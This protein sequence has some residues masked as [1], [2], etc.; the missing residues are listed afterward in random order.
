MSPRRSSSARLAA[1]A[2]AGLAAVSALAT[3]SPAHAVSGVTTARIAGNDRY[4]T[5]AAIALK[6]YTTADTVIVASG[7]SF[8]DALAG[9]AL[10]SRQTAP[11]LL[12][13]PDV[14]STP[15]SDAIAAL[16]ATKAVILGGTSAVSQAVEDALAKK[17]SVSRISGADRYDTAAKIA[18]AIGSTNIGTT[19]TRRSALIATGTGFAD[20]LAG[21]PLSAAGSSGVLPV[22]LVND[23]VPAATK[24]ALQD[25]G[26]TQTIILGGT[27]AVSTA[28][29]NDLKTI[30]GNAPTRL[31]GADRYATASAIAVAE[32]TTFGFTA[33]N[34]YL[35]NGINFADAL[36][37]G[38]L[39]GKTKSPILLSDAASLASATKTFLGDHSAAIVTVTALG[40]T[41]ALSDATL[42]A[43]KTAASGSATDRKNETIVVTPQDK[44]ILVN[45]S[46]AT[47]SYTATGVTSDVDIVLVNCTNVSTSTSGNTVFANT[48]ADGTADGTASAG[49]GANKAST[50]ASISTVNGAPTLPSANDDYADKASPAA[51]K[52]TF[53]VKAG[54]AV[55]CVVPVVFVDSDS[56]NSLASSATGLPSE[57]FGTGGIVEFQPAV[58]KTGQFDAV[59][60]QSM[61]DPEG[62]FSAVSSTPGSAAASYFY[63]DTDG[64]KIGGVASDKASFVTAMTIGDTVKGDYRP[65]A[66]STFDL[67]DAAPAAPSQFPP[68]ADAAP[69]HSVKLTFTDSSTATTTSYNVYRA[70]GTLVAGPPASTSCPAT[71]TAVDL[72]KYVLVGNPVVDTGTS[73][74]PPYSFS[75]SSTAAAT[76]YCY[77]VRSVESGDVGPPP[78][79]AS[80]VTTN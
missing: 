33:A 68:S 42:D 47:R 60:V 1:A 67:T 16:K 8:P 75:D 22:L 70:D 36:A 79:T 55:A 39:G 18:A 13:A 80:S 6:A 10:A 57:A 3:I 71:N 30:T 61:N 24:S 34:V 50:P 27:G 77:I 15:A 11:V 73:P 51:G 43:A 54:S 7:V 25:L 52:V 37:A 31:A 69:A 58:A 26:I 65:G 35:G 5:A 78:A 46:S 56:S 41:S 12:T 21:G 23:A 19:S 2:I 14:L 32:L 74:T 29:E 44:S 45:D 66:V 20:A 4:Q 53:D 49:S 72:A 59:T 76:R 48:D 40:G 64:Y 28:V 9:A 62:S 38:A 17:V 63:D